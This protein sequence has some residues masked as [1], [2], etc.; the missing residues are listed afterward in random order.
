MQD[1]HATLVIPED[2]VDS[3]QLSAVTTKGFI[4]QWVIWGLILATNILATGLIIH[5]VW[6]VDI[7][8]IPDAA[9]VGSFVAYSCQV[10]QSTHLR[11]CQAKWPKN[12]DQG[13]RNAACRV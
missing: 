1:G 3:D 4:A 10:P 12:E 6:Y 5:K 9:S 8:V 7:L 13:F 11:A 2:S